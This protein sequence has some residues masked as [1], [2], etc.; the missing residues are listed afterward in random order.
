MSLDVLYFFHS[1][2]DKRSF[3]PEYTRVIQPENNSGPNHLI[4]NKQD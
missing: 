4:E 3:F 1:L 2:F